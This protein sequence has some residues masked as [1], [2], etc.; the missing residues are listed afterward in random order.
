MRPTRRIPEGQSS[1]PETRNKSYW[2]EAR[3][4]WRRWLSIWQRIQGAPKTRQSTGAKVYPRWTNVPQDNHQGAGTESR[5]VRQVPDLPGLNPFLLT[6]ETSLPRSPGIQFCKRSALA[7]EIV[8]LG[9]RKYINFEY[10]TQLK[11]T[12]V[13]ACRYARWSCRLSSDPCPHLQETVC[14]PFSRIP[15]KEWPNSRQQSRTSGMSTKKE[16]GC[17]ISLYWR[18]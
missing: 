16:Q 5:W 17:S 3:G 10:S 2:S 13:E 18:G 15:A 6:W 7:E 11:Y 4:I 9:K 1:K 8:Y 12:N 14:P